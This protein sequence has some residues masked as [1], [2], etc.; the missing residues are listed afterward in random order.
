M[1]NQKLFTQSIHVPECRLLAL[2][3]L[4]VCARDLQH[5]THLDSSVLMNHASL[6]SSLWTSRQLLVLVVH[7]SFPL[8]QLLA[9]PFPPF[10]HPIELE[11]PMGKDSEWVYLSKVAF[12]YLRL[13][14]LLL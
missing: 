11:L 4:V 13:V 9:N 2:R 7:A 3:G 8:T 12:L 1:L 14:L 10:S 6:L 5:P